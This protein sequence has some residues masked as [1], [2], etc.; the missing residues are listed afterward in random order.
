[1]DDAFTVIVCAPEVDASAA[2]ALAGRAAPDGAEALI[3]PSEELARFFEREV[4]RKLPRGY[5]LVLCGLQVVHVDWDGNLVRPRLMKRLRS[6]VGEAKWYGAAPWHPEDR[7]AVGHMIGEENLL[8]D[9]NA[10]SVAR[11]MLDHL[12]EPGSDYDEQLAR[13][14]AG[15]DL[16]EEVNWA[17][18]LRGVLTALK[19]DRRMLAE[20][21]AELIEGRPEDVVAEHCEQAEKVH[22]ENRRFARENCGDPRPMREMKLVELQLPPERHPFWAE[23]G[24]Y[25]REEKEVEFSLCRLEA[26]PT[27]LLARRDDLR[28][29]LRTWARYVTD[30]MPRAH[31]VGAR[32]E[33]VPL[34]VEGLNE[35]PALQEEVL[36]LLKEGAHLL[37][38]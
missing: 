2:A 5:D 15:R 18:D 21:I 23:I 6:F 31:A 7:R 4:Q 28:V 10:G 30:L 29:D 27:L 11:L 19:A 38:D 17:E 25:A 8:V 36:E 34:V 12:E 14:G 33:V 24:S 9:P 1:M 22:E 37:R 26:R 3:F 16:G 13:F 20:A 32:P 35:T